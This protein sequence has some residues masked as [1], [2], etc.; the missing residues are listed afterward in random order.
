MRWLFASISV[1]LTSEGYDLP[2]VDGSNPKSVSP[3][4][5][6]M[7]PVIPENMDGCTPLNSCRFTPGSEMCMLAVALRRDRAHHCLFMNRPQVAG[8]RLS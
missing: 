4:L 3:S 8:K 7:H 6:F 5:I 1:K 2:E